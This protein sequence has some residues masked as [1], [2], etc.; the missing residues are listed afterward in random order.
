MDLFKTDLGMPL[1]KRMSP[2]D[3]AEFVG[4]E[5]IVGEGRLLRR[6]IEADRLNSLI[7]SGP[8]GTGKT[9]LAN[10]IARKTQAEFIQLN[11]VN[12][13]VAELRE[14]IEKAKATLA[15]HKRRTILFLDEIHRFNKAQQDALL[16]DVESGVIILIGATTENPYFS[17][18]PALISRSQV[19]EFKALTGPESLQIIE[20]C[21][22]KYPNIA[23]DDD[24]KKHL[25]LMAGGDARKIL[26]AIDLA[27]LTTPEKEKKIQITLSIIEE[28]IQK[29][30]IVYDESAHYDII[31]AFIKSMRGSDPDAALY[32]L[33]KM[34][35]AGEDPRFIARRIVICA[36]EDVGNADPL[37]LLIANAALTTVAEIGYPEARLTLAQA[38]V[39]VAAAPKSNAA[40]SAINQALADVESGVDF[41]VPPHLL[42]A[43]YEQEKKKGKGSGYKYAHD[44]PNAYVKEQKYLPENRKYYTPSN[45]GYEKKIQDWLKWL[46]E[47]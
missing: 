5:H 11:A 34:I 22:R 23:M 24:A 31:S 44:F 18:N 30:Q 4:Q 46:K 10:L 14:V 7:F 47:H 6:A 26:N 32:W 38:A 28:S 20:N 39:Y 41:A 33:A 29:K 1:A 25:V 36:S 8:P 3:F 16:P 21:L 12:S 45:R 19:F 37:A 40:Y 13:K 17:V 15:Y 9:A 35:Y 27:V 2:Q 43:V 42:N